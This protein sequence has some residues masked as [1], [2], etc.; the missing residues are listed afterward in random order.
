MRTQR[1]HGDRSQTNVNGRERAPGPAE[2]LT[3]RALAAASFKWPGRRGPRRN[4]GPQG[5]PLGHGYQPE[6]GGH[7]CSRGIR[8]GCLAVGTPAMPPYLSLIMSRLAMPVQRKV[9]LIK[10]RLRTRRPAPSR[11]A[12]ARCKHGRIDLNVDA[13][14]A[15]GSSPLLAGSGG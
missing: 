4:G 8:I 2:R 3:A 5:Q 11:V 15:P 10:Y 9:C 14:A 1:R 13:C 7:G 6:T 12:Q